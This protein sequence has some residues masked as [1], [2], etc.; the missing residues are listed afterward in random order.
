MSESIAPERKWLA[1]ALLAAAQFV[2]VLDA[3]IVNVALPS[4][5]SSG[6]RSQA[7]AWSS[8]SFVTSGALMAR[9]VRER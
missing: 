5:S 6:S 2:V 9:Q 8:G 1:L 3:S 7:T 4:P